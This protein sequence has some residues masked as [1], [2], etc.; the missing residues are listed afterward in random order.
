[1]S[2][3]AVVVVAGSGP[4]R[5]VSARLVESAERKDLEPAAHGHHPQPR[6][7]IWTAF[8]AMALIASRFSGNA[9]RRGVAA[10]IGG[11]RPLTDP[12]RP[13]PPAR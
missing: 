12:D 11:G 7:Q 6:R 1:M 2:A 8:T 9:G 5:D 13:G 4:A 3:A 10:Q